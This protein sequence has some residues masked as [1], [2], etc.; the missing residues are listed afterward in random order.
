MDGLQ[1]VSAVVWI[2]LACKSG[3]LLLMLLLHLRLRLYALAISLTMLRMH[4][5]MYAFMLTR[6]NE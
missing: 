2:E 3:L 5:C 4:V 6:M 1:S